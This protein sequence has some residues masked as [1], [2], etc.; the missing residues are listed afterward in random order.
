MAAAGDLPKRLA[1]TH[2]LASEKAASVGFLVKALLLVGFAGVCR[3]A[4]TRA[5]SWHHAIALGGGLVAT[6]F[7]TSLAAYYQYGFGG[8]E[9]H[10]TFQQ[11]A[12]VLLL[13][14]AGR[15]IGSRLPIKP[16]IAGTVGMVGLIVAI[17]VGL[18]V[19]LP[20]LVSDYRLL[21]EIQQAQQETWTSGIDASVTTM[22]FVLPP[23]G[24][25]LTAM[26]FSTGHFD[27]SFPP[28][29]SDPFYMH[30]LLGFFGK[31]SIDLVAYS[32]AGQTP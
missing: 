30:C 1:G 28:K 26:P 31:S 11:C 12:V 17:S 22:R 9:R 5:I 3:A 7:L 15:V 16:A 32:R 29:S 13:L 14:L 20:G 8:F 10:D 21:P 2:G 18:G 23:P 24:A 6:I 19:R 25:V 27:N 4:M